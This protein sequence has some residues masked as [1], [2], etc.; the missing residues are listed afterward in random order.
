MKCA[1]KTISQ[2]GDLKLCSVL[3]NTKHGVVDSLFL[4]P[5]RAV[6]VQIQCLKD[7]IAV[8]EKT[9]FILE[10]PLLWLFSNGQFVFAIT[11]THRLLVARVSDKRDRF[12]LVSDTEILETDQ[13]FRFFSASLSNNFFCVAGCDC[14]CL[15]FD[16]RCPSE[17]K[18]EPI[19][20]GERMV[21]DLKAGKEECFNILTENQDGQRELVVDANKA[22]VSGVVPLTLML[23]VCCMQVKL[24]RLK[25]W[26]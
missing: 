22:S 15:V 10:T 21:I 17:P 9:S 18:C 14:Y 26:K 3:Q 16:V 4:Y 20:L 2:A 11:E 5:R 1:H 7:K 12:E 13:E 23:S 25:Q 6:F 8:T 24:S 19:W